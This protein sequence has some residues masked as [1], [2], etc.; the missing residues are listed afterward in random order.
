MFLFPFFSVNIITDYTYKDTNENICKNFSLFSS[1]DNCVWLI[2]C[3][4]AFF[5]FSGKFKY[6]F[7]IFNY[8]KIFLM[9]SCNLRNYFLHDKYYIKFYGYWWKKYQR[10]GPLYCSIV[11]YHTTALYLL[12][13]CTVTLYCTVPLYSTVPLYCEDENWNCEGSTWN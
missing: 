5:L 4:D 12:L 7:L 10:R 8:E 13:Y 6:K 3:R 2:L 11:M 9:N 1:S